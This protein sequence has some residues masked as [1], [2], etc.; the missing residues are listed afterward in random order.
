M[1]RRLTQQQQ[2]IADM[3]LL[4]MQGIDNGR[5]S[6]KLEELISAVLADMYGHPET[7]QSVSKTVA[8]NYWMEKKKFRSLLFSLR[9]ELEEHLDL[10]VAIVSLDHWVSTKIGES[11][12]PSNSSLAD[13]LHKVRTVRPDTDVFQIIAPS[14]ADR[15]SPTGKHNSAGIYV[16][17][18]QHDPIYVVCL[19]RQAKSG[20]GARD[21]AKERLEKNGWDEESLRLYFDRRQ[22]LTVSNVMRIG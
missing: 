5:I 12:Y 3:R 22:A 11:I 7:R 17:L 2:L 13:R 18:D 9:Q 6:F 1:V 16:A 10:T 8:K 20:S 21:K 19:Y 15:S 14:L 4:V